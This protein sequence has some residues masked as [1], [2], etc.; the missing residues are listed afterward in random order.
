MEKFIFSVDFVILDMEADEDVPITY[1]RPFLGTCDLLVEVRLGR[2]TLILG[3]ERVVF[4]LA[5]TLKKP[6]SY[7]SY[8]FIESIHTSDVVT[9]WLFPS[10]GILNSL[11]RVITDED[12]DLELNPKVEETLTFLQ[13]QHDPRPSSF[14][15]L[16]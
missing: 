12:L 3:D 16:E 7:A 13:S 6:F 1:G 10:L 15:R 9:R 11:E 14:E 8:S 4:N 2:L 5:D